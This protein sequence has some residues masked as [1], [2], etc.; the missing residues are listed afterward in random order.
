MAAI[1]KTATTTAPT[2]IAR[3]AVAQLRSTNDK[4]SN[5]L[6]I[7]KC[8]GWAKRDGARM[9][10]LPECLGFMGDS[11]QHTLDN[12]DPPIGDLLLEEES[13]CSQKFLTTM[14]PFRKA[15]ADTIESH[16]GASLG[17]NNA[18]M[19]ESESDNRYD[20]AMSFASI[21]EELRFIARESKLWI[22]G[23]GVHTTAAVGVAP[24]DERRIYNTHVIIDDEGQIRAHYHKI[25][26]F[27]VS[28]PGKVKLRESW[29]TLRGDKLVVCDSPIG[30]LGLSI[31]YDLR[32]SEMYVDLVQG[33]G[34]EVLL[35]PSAFTVTTGRAH[36]HALLKARA[37]ES[38]CYVLAAAQ[39]GQHN[40]KRQ[41][42]GHSIVYDPWGELVADAGGYDG[43]GFSGTVLEPPQGELSPVGV[44]SII[45]SEIDLDKLKSVRE[46]MP[47]QQHR[48]NSS[49]SH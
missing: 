13:T 26:L 28:I 22:S 7:A 46:R 3:A 8:A 2:R 20:D 36:W 12:A 6:N 14:T 47:I 23:G 16:A 42:Y 29:T 45:I 35:V 24:G 38:Q 10:F 40:E 30:K 18:A 9:L 41:S 37:I 43:T 48:N 25:H 44:P 5:L 49:F 17:N 21:I 15:L 33:M 39:V 1:A 11:A 32:F 31:C 19:G 34:A 27:D 4:R